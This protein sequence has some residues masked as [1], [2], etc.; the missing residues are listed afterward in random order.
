MQPGCQEWVR[1]T[2]IPYWQHSDS[3]V[4]QQPRACPW[5]QTHPLQRRVSWCHI[6]DV[7]DPWRWELGIWAWC[8][9]RN[10]WLSA[11]D[12]W[13][14]E[15]RG[16][17]LY[18]VQRRKVAV[19]VRKGSSQFSCQPSKPGVLVVSTLTSLLMARPHVCNPIG[20]ASLKWPCSPQLIFKVLFAD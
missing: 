1:V 17:M 10:P 14:P 16:G 2:V 19:D 6:W 11:L 18:M 7:C 9:P 3:G 20:V 13:E 12:S 4:C 5:S 8:V 15:P